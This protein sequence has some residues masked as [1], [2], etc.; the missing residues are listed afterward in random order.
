MAKIKFMPFEEK[1]TR[2][3]M[4]VTVHKNDDYRDVSTR[5][6]TYEMTDSEWSLFLAGLDTAGIDYERVNDTA[7]VIVKIKEEKS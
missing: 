1:R 4:K 6:R 5:T 7:I 2:G 3:V